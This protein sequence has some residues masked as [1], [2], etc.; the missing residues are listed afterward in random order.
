[1]EACT[2]QATI[3]DLFLVMPKNGPCPE[4]AVTS[5]RLFKDQRNVLSTSAGAGRYRIEIQA[6][7]ADDNPIEVSTL[8]TGTVT[9]I[10][11]DRG[12]AELEV[13]GSRVRLGDIVS[14]G[15]PSN[16]SPDDGGAE[17]G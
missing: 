17:G 8:S 3:P 10:Y 13:E 7:D 15:A 4:R 16:A 12:L 11:F 14:V 2:R 6:Y 1:M 5:V 9:G